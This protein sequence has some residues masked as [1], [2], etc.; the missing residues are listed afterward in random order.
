EK[1]KWKRGFSAPQKE[2]NIMKVLF[3]EGISVPEPIAIGHA[4][5]NGKI[6]VWLISRFIPGCVT[7]DE[8]RPDWK[9]PGAKEQVVK[10]AQLISGMHAAFIVHRDLHAGNLLWQAKE[11]KWYLTD[12]QHARRGFCTRV[13]LEEDITQLQHCLGKKVPIRTRIEFLKAYIWNF[14]VIT[15]TTETH[16][17]RDYH[18]VW[19]EVAENIRGYDLSQA[20]HRSRRAFKSNRDFMPLKV[21]NGG[22]GFMRKGES[23]VLVKDVCELLEKKDWQNEKYVTRFERKGNACSAIYDHPQGKVAI[24]LQETKFSLWERLFPFKRAERRIWRA[25]ARLTLL[26][27]PCERPLLIGRSANS[28]AYVYLVRGVFNFMEAFQMAQN[29]PQKREQM[30]I[31]LAKLAARMHNCGIAHGNFFCEQVAVAEDGAIY[32]RNF[33]KMRFSSNCSWFRRVDDL[34]RL[35]TFSG[36]LLSYCEQRLF[37]R[38]Y[39][40]NLVETIDARL[41]ITDVAYKAAII[42]SEE[43]ER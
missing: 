29:D 12:F 28:Y 39:I 13:Q 30:L 38:T 7:Y 40:A 26:H 41:L 21:W 10:L 5:E 32:I 16:S 17:R 37:I 31:K 27:I 42:L 19:H 1:L 20:K 6:K 35:L 2:W 33:R 25:A 11:K 8:M 36:S 43:N 22:K 14:A 15:E 4:E 24:D 3:K 23:Q 18:S 34:A 9:A